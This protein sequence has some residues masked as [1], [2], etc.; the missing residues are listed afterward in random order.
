VPSYYPSLTG[1]IKITAF[2]CRSISVLSVL[3]PTI[4]KNCL[5]SWSVI[6]GD[7]TNIDFLNNASKKGLKQEY[8]Q[9]RN[10]VFFVCIWSRGNGTI[11]AVFKCRTSN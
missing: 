6:V 9:N 1:T 7:N 8:G 5:L 10:D 4:L 3:T 11:S 2:S